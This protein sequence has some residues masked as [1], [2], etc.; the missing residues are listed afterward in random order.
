MGYL[1]GAA[2]ALV[3][4]AVAIA[5]W[6][7]TALE[8]AVDARL[9]STDEELRRLGDADSWRERGSLEARR[10][11]TEFRGALEELRARDEERRSRE[12]EVWGVLHRVAGVLAG[13]QRTGRAGENV[14]RDALA[15]LPPSM[16]VNDFR[17]NGRV[18]E[19]GLILP[20][21]RRLPID[22]KWPADRELI[23]LQETDDP[24]EIDRLGRLVER[25]VAERA[26]EVAQYRDPSVTA[27]VGVA[28]VPDAAYAVLR[29]AHADAYR[30]GVIVVP[31][32]MALPI[33][34]FLHGLVS[35][36]GSA[37]D[38]DECL[39]DLSALLDAMES[40]LENKLARASTMLSNGA[41]EL[42]AEVGKA[43]A[44]LARSGGG[45][46]QDGEPRP[47][48]VGIRP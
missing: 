39:R 38:V 18:V 26:R 44:T 37:G 32:S 3:A 43:R 1:V 8:R 31:Y 24:A 19:F 36:F 7:P 29:R 14:L 2:V 45:E 34:L 4:V 25:T 42:R 20:D 28:A 33:V 40:T 27:P 48:L 6:M 16:I 35:R 9:R 11:I 5:V 17:V 47:R 22:S 41:E 13:G 10:E 15:H 23:A 12:D 21:G 46:E 30:Q